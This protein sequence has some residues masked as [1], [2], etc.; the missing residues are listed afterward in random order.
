VQQ[1]DA[2]EKRGGW[3]GAEQQSERKLVGSTKVQQV[4]EAERRRL[5]PI[6]KRMQDER[7]GRCRQKRTDRKK[8]R[9]EWTRGH[10][11]K[12]KR[13]NKEH[14]GKIAMQERRIGN[15]RDQ[16]RTEEEKES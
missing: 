3:L 15:S 1:Q 8:L 16:G 5:E 6:E 10:A 9:A 2:A 11:A 12:N 4:K 14:Y 13:S 7:A